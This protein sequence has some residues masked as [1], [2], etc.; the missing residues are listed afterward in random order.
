MARDDRSERVI[1]HL[2]EADEV[3]PNETWSHR[4]NCANCVFTNWR[5]FAARTTRQGD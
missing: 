4:S 2:I 5:A 3:Q 1:S